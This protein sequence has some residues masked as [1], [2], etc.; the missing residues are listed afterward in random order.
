MAPLEGNPLECLDESYPQNKRDVI[1]YG[2]N[3]MI[4]TSTDL[5]TQMCD[6]QT[7]RQTVG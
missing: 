1:L 4:L 3:C 7:D 6:R 5:T 2:E